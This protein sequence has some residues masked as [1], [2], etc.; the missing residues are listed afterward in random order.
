MKAGGGAKRNASIKRARRYPRQPRER[1]PPPGTV[2][3]IN[4]VEIL[5]NL[6]TYH[7]VK[8]DR[9]GECSPETDCLR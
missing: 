4:S 9:P 6:Y 1:Q 3:L 8:Y 5:T 7:K 2:T